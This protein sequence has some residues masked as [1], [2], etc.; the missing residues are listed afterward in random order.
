MSK[1]AQRLPEALTY[2]TQTKLQ[3][4]AAITIDLMDKENVVGVS[5]SVQRRCWR[6][7]LHIGKKQVF[8]GS[9]DTK[10]EAVSAR[11]NAELRF[12]RRS[13]TERTKGFGRSV[14]APKFLDMDK[15]LT[16]LYEEAAEVIHVTS[17]VMRF[18]IKD[19]LKGQEFTNQQRLGRE[20]G[21]LLTMVNLLVM[22]GDVKDED[23]EEGMKAKVESLE[24]VY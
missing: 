18:G 22:S 20:I 21:N 15:N 24:E 7:Y 16:H 4:G 12:C 9:Y 5:Y 11:F 8:S 6:A 13:V 23:I 19:K 1:K 3:A 10:D 2:I 14:K 17:K